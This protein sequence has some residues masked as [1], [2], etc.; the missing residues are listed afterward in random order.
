M[1]VVGYRLYHKTRFKAAFYVTDVRITS[2][3]TVK[4]A[5]NHTVLLTASC[6]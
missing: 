3:T 2:G 4:N 1:D 6:F 5:N